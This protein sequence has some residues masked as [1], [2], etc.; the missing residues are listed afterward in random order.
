M[1]SKP[2]TVEQDTSKIEGNA[3]LEVKD[4]VANVFWEIMTNKL[5][6]YGFAYSV[7]RRLRLKEISYMKKVEEP[8]RMEGRVVVEIVVDKGKP[9]PMLMVHSE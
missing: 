2:E 3:S 1:S 8:E 9:E 5:N 4:F 7:G 6:G